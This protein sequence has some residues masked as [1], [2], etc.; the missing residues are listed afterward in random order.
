ML[1]PLEF[2]QRLAALIP[3]P[4]LRLIAYARRF[5]RVLRQQGDSLLP[6]IETTPERRV[7]AIS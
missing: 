7:P 1:T 3:P 5:F 4:R 6:L 2:M